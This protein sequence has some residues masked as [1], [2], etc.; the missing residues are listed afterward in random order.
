MKLPPQLRAELDR[1]II[2]R[3]FGGYQHLAEWLQAQ[4]YQISD[5][6]I[7]RYGAKLQR[8]LK[9]IE[10]VGLLA[11]YEDASRS[12]PEGIDLP[13]LAPALEPDRVAPV[14]DDRRYPGDAPA[15]AEDTRG[16]PHLTWLG[17]PRGSLPIFPSRLIGF[18]KMLLARHSSGSPHLNCRSEHGL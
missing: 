5:D 17:A 15:L 4:G 6:S 8:K 13:A 2:D 16:L 1:R 3:G 7:Q 14:S 9:A 18:P 11:E 12:A 10:L